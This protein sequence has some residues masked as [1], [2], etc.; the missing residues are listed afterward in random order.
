LIR[1]SYKNNFAGS[2]TTILFTRNLILK[3]HIY[4]CNF[5]KI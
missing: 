4:F 1:K 5:A 2:Q 3:L